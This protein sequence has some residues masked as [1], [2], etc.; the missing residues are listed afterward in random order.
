M[1]RPAQNLAV[2][3][4]A[5]TIQLAIESGQDSSALRTLERELLVIVETMNPTDV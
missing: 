2:A 5:F 4:V 3:A 1:E